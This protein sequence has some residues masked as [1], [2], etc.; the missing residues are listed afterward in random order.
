MTILFR[1]DFL[2]TLILTDCAELILM[3]KLFFWLLYTVSLPLMFFEILC[4][5]ASSVMSL[6][7]KQTQ[8]DCWSHLISFHGLIVMQFFFKLILAS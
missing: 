6:F 3:G 1:M 2:V 7:P 8:F 5:S 4:S